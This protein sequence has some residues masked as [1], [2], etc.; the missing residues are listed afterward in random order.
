M[1]PCYHISQNIRSAVGDEMS[2]GSFATVKLGQICQI[3]SAFLLDMIGNAFSKSVL[4][5]T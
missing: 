4:V 3:V 2:A 1:Q 5:D